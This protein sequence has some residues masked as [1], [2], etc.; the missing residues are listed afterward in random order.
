MTQVRFF[1]GISRNRIIGY[2]IIVLTFSCNLDLF[3]DD[4]VPSI[5]LTDYEGNSAVS[6]VYNNIN[7][8]NDI[9]VDNPYKTGI[10]TSSKCTKLT[11]TADWNEV[12]FLTFNTTIDLSQYSGI[13]YKIYATAKPT[14]HLK[15][16]QNTNTNWW[17]NPDNILAEVTSTIIPTCNQWVADTIRFFASGSGL[18]YGFALQP[19]V[20]GI[21]YIDDVVLIGKKPVVQREGLKNLAKAKGKNI[22]TAVPIQT[23]ALDNSRA[24][25]QLINSEFNYSIADNDNKFNYIEPQKGVFAFSRM[26]VFVNKCLAQGRE[27][28]GMGYVWH[29][30]NPTWLTNGNFSRNEMLAIMKNHITTS[31]QRYKGKIKEWEIVNEAWTSPGEEGIGRVHLRTNSVWY[32]AIGPD[33]IDSAFV[34]AH[35][36]DPDAKLF[37]NDYGAELMT[38]KADSIFNWLKREKAKGIPI[39]GVGMQCHLSPGNGTST[40]ILSEMDLNVKRL[41]S[42]GMEVSITELDY[43]LTTT[44]EADF[45]KQAQV[46]R[47][48]AKVWLDNPN[49]KTL[50]FWGLID[51]ESWLTL[52]EYGGKKAPLLFDDN[53]NPKLCYY[54]IQDLINETEEVVSPPANLTLKVKSTVAILLSWSDPKLK[55]GTREYIIYMNGDSVKRTTELSFNFTGLKPATSYTFT[56]KSTNDI[57]VSSVESSPITGITKAPTGIGDVDLKD[58]ILVYPNPVGKG[59]SFKIELGKS[60]DASITISNLTGEQIFNNRISGDCYNFPYLNISGVYIINIVSKDLNFAQKIVFK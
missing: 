3:A 4:P 57:G 13:A 39:H 14:T 50:I 8:P 33:Y 23:F 35:R 54:G 29:Q 37:Y 46:F 45:L 59:N 40:K 32:K 52:P 60:V 30:S 21:Y 26:D 15:V 17:E 6:N 12:G 56:V 34:F 20:N 27:V 9:T 1:S 55:Y 58:Q 51:R 5:L 48:V 43:G 22:G 11:V 41:N 18:T 42:I 24:D 47:A 25:V 28:R 38:E 2:I 31:M 44:T 36:A 49:L 19:K 10:N 53:L 7:L 16:I